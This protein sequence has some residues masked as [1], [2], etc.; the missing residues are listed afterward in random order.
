MKN[1]IAEILNINK[2]ASGHLCLNITEKICWEDFP[3]YAESIVELLRGEIFSRTD[4]PDIRLWNVVINGQNYRLAFDDYPIAVSLESNDDAAD[5]EI[6]KIRDSL[7][8]QKR[9]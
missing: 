4:G 3:E 6:L 2:M 8:A 5:K 1:L 7:A 9:S